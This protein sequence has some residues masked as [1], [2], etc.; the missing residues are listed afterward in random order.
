MN[1]DDK[2]SLLDNIEEHF[3]KLGIEDMTNIVYEPGGDP[4]HGSGM[5]DWTTF[6]GTDAL[7]VRCWEMLSGEELR[8]QSDEGPTFDDALGAQC[9]AKERE[10]DALAIKYGNKYGSSR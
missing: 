1:D 8:R 5:D 10:R 4:G 9:D 2:A 3:S 6:G 7:L